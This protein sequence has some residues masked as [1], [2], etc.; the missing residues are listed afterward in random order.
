MLFGLRENLSLGSLRYLAIVTCMLFLCAYSITTSPTPLSCFIIYIYR[1]SLAE[2]RSE[3]PL[4]AQ[5]LRHDPL[6]HLR[7]LEAACHAIAAEERPG[8]DKDSEY[9]YF[10]RANFV[11]D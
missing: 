7:A 1:V 10:A 9:R 11:A 5:R 4:L 3:N 8:Y 6:R 2:L